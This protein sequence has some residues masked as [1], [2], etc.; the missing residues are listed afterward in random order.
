MLYYQ[1]PTSWTYLF[2]VNFTNDNQFYDNPR[3]MDNLTLY[4]ILPKHQ[5]P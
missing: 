2:I 3:H 1:A 5:I 4:K